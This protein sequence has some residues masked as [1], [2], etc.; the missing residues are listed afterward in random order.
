MPFGIC[1]PKP[2]PLGVPQ[3]QPLAKVTELD[4]ASI[5]R[6]QELVLN[7]VGSDVAEMVVRLIGVPEGVN[8]IKSHPVMS[9]QGDGLITDQ[10]GQMTG[11][12]H[13]WTK[14][15]LRNQYY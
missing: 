1:I 6:E 5:Q 7:S 4:T 2:F 12:S 13:R 8:D 11:L 14:M 9:L 10:R 3:C 15:F